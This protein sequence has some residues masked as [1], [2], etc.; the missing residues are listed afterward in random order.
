MT[1]TSSAAR[2]LAE[3]GIE[4]RKHVLGPD[5][6]ERSM[7]SATS[8]NRDFQDLLNT[9]CWGEIWTREGLSRELRSMINIAL[10]V[11]L[12][13]PAEL[14]NHVRGALRNGV[15]VEQIREV[16]LQT[17]IYCGV[18]AASLAFKAAADELDALGVRI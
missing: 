1:T 13:Q 4:V 15:T 7:N 9:Y 14:R 16:L 2:S 11:A 18:P 3:R 8:F 17:T 10:M 12:N 5:Y 6:V